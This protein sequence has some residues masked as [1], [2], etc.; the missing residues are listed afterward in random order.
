M[1][2]ALIAIML[3][4]SG[5]ATAP[6]YQ[7][8]N[9]SD[10]GYS[11][12]KIEDDHYR[13]SYNGDA[14]TP[15]ETV[16]NFLLYRMSEVTLE[17]GYD[18]FK[19]IDSDTECHTKYIETTDGKPCNYYRP[20]GAAFPYYGYGYICDSTTRIYESKR[21]EAVAFISLFHG[22]KPSND[23]FAFDARAVMSN[24]ENKIHP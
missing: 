13:I 9:G 11:D 7:A 20:Y 2:Y 17:Q 24:L 6:V 19:V 10:F 16:E 15:R 3:G 23:A 1:K 12:Q 18:Y 8:A 22:E 14:S 21:Y 5:C 4:L